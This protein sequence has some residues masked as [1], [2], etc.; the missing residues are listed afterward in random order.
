MDPFA[1][2]DDDDILSVGETRHDNNVPRS[3][4]SVVFPA[5]SR[6]ETATEKTA[7]EK[8]KSRL[9]Q[10]LEENVRIIS[11]IEELVNSI[12]TEPFNAKSAGDLEKTLCKI[13]KLTKMNLKSLDGLKDTL[14]MD[15]SDGLTPPLVFTESL[16]YGLSVPQMCPVCAQAINK[17]YDKTC[18]GEVGRLIFSWNH[19][20]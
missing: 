11:I 12:S 20:K 16:R 2:Q 17:P 1:D 18:I 5:A 3:C 10:S 6:M 7:G 19:S 13:K 8:M 15:I 4:E 9:A 14:L